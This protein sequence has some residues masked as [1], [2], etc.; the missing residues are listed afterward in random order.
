MLPEQIEKD[1]VYHD[2]VKS[3]GKYL[4]STRRICS[5]MEDCLDRKKI[6]FFPLQEVLDSVS[7]KI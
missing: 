1:N 4:E 3:P 5:A 6:H 2:L 7:R